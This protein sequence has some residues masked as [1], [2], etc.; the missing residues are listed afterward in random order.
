[1][2]DKLDDIL[3]KLFNRG[4]NHGLSKGQSDD[5][6]FN[7]VA[8]AHSDILALIDEQEEEN[9]IYCFKLL[10]R[11][12]DNPAS[13]KIHQEVGSYISEINS[14]GRKITRHHRNI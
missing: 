1:M 6:E 11:F 13:F 3:E 14:P 7:A 4:Y 12:H 5:G 8:K 10:E 9:F 2:N